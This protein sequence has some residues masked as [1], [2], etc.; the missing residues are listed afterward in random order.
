MFKALDDFEALMRVVADDR[1]PVGAAASA[2]DRY[3]IRF[4]LVDDFPQC[5]KFTFEMQSRFNVVVCD[6]ARWRDADFPD[7]M[8][9]HNALARK[10]EEVVGGGGDCVIVPF[11]ELV[12][13]FRNG[14]GGEFEAVLRT[15]KGF[16]ASPSAQK[17]HQRVYVPLV[18]LAGRMGDFADDNQA[19]IWRLRGGGSPS[20]LIIADGSSFGVKG[21]EERFEIVGDVRGWLSLWARREP[22]PDRDIVC[23]SRS[24]FANA[25]NADPDNAFSFRVCHGAYEFLVNGLGLDLGSARQCAGEDEYWEWLA[26]R[27]DVRDFSL[28]QFVNAHFNV[29]DCRDTDTFFGLWLSRRDVRERW[30]LAKYYKSNAPDDDFIGGLLGSLDVLTGNKLVEAVAASVPCRGDRCLEARRRCLEMAAEEGVRLGNAAEGRLLDRLEALAAN[31]GGANAAKYFTGISDGEFHLAIRWV[32]RGVLT[33]RQIETFYPDLCRYMSALS[34]QGM[35]DWAAGY[36]DAY[37]EAKLRNEYTEAVGEKLSQVNGSESAFRAW[38]GDLKTTRTLLCGREDV[39]VFY[40]VDGLGVDWIPFVRSVVEERRDAGLCL[41]E[42]LVAAASLPTTTLVNKPDLLALG[43]ED[44]EKSGDLD[45]LAHSPAN[46]WPAVIADEI[47]QVRQIVEGVLDRFS[48]KTMAIVSDHGLTWLAQMR[49]G[50]NLSGAVAD[51][52]G[53]AATR[54]SGGWT[55]DDNYVVVDDGA[56]ACA[57]RHES[58]C[59]KVPSGQ[60]AHGGC[61]PE[62][63]MVPVFIIS[64]SS[65]AAPWV[66]ELLTPD[67]SGA[68]PHLRFSIRGVR[69]GASL[70]AEYGGRQYS[71][72]GGEGDVF[73]CGPLVVNPAVDVVRIVVD[74]VRQEFKVRISS[75]ATEDNLF[76]GL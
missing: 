16:E 67:V 63:V 55:P 25:G 38:H 56:T 29:R 60:G 14:R 43:G 75:G 30:L 54:S 11:S 42:I 32:G 5:A 9:T 44:L 23:T 73:S 46:K 37:R 47:R 17:R 12:R 65:A 28:A 74:G 52:H 2:A 45:S 68:S 39:E 19:T 59:G 18:G 71:L 22:V 66:A 36:F 58:L 33:L 6:A 72:R 62:E 13:F 69:R 64:S 20:R 48:G 40:W 27:I 49:G 21:L 24:I 1:V 70:S 51:H 76:P 35:P 53:R 57:L 41:R 3:P 8:L 4:V 50:L 10:V 15:V 34:A 31:S 26:G 7:S 61:T